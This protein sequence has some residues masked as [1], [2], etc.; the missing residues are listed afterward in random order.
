MKII[1]LDETA[2]TN[3]WLREHPGTEHATVV[4]TRCQSAGRGQRGNSWE[5]EPGAN[6]TFSILVRCHN[7]PPSRQMAIS[8]A[9]ALAIARW[10]RR[11]LP[12]DKEVA[13]K[14]PNDIYVGDKKICGI[15]IEHVLTC[16]KIERTVIGAG[17]NIN[18]RQF[19]SDAPNPVSLSQLTGKEYP[20]EKMLQEVAE[21]II[22]LVEAEDEN[23]GVLTA[24]AYRRN[25]WR[26]D[27]FHP[28]RNAGGDFLARIADIAPD[29]TI[30]L[31]RPDGSISQYAFKEVTAIL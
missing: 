17:I 3:T 21:G 6:L 29:G 15:L 20:L 5:S 11:Y 2:S 7:I 8:R 19:L 14:W 26:R 1:Q 10:L 16:G 4:A 9:T 22:S 25:L 23:G 18:Q 24:D 31:E 30:S 12:D 27:G 28:Y 13:V